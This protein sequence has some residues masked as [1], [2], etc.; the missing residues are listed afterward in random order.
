MGFAT[1]LGNCSCVALPPA[2][3]Q[4]YPSYA[5]DEETQVQDKAVAA[6]N[7]ALALMINQYKAGAVSY[8][9]VMTAQTTALSNRQTAVQLHSNRM[10][11]S[12]Q[13]V[14]ALGGWNVAM[15][16]SPDQAGGEVK[17]TDYLIFPVD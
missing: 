16:P 12:V 8:L 11:A 9:N 4:S 10:S 3:I 13:L 6:A 15:L 1:A 5:L 7:Q 2:S 14:K 17:W